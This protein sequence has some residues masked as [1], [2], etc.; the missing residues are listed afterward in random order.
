MQKC[1]QSPRLPATTPALQGLMCVGKEK[2]GWQNQ[3]CQW[4]TTSAS[5]MPQS[6]G[7]G[8]HNLMTLYCMFFKT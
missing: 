6:L 2:Q 8:R 1:G 3:G 5:H 7:W 4:Q